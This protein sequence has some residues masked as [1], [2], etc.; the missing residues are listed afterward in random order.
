M[1]CL[2]SIYDDW[3]NLL[4][5]KG[6]GRA[7]D[8]DGLLVGSG[9]FNTITHRHAPNRF[10]ARHLVA[11]I[12]NDDDADDADAL[13]C[14][15]YPT[16]LYQQSFLDTSRRGSNIKNSASYAVSLIL[17]L[18][19]PPPLSSLVFCRTKEPAAD[20]R[21]TPDSMSKPSARSMPWHVRPSS[22]NSICALKQ[23]QQ[24]ELLSIP[25]ELGAGFAI[26]APTMLPPHHHHPQQQPHDLGSGAV[27]DFLHLH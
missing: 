16:A 7:Q 10:A 4:L 25:C 14:Q 24:N 20:A 1:P 17:P 8:A 2:C 23:E 15:V 13:P 11:I 19:L 12:A 3:P 21:R 9:L 27:D 18:S 6:C 5:A 22:S 26:S